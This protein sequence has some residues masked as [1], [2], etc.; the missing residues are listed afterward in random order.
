MLYKPNFCCQCGEKIQRIDWNLRASRRFCDLCQT[1]FTVYEL[2]PK[3]GLGIGLLLG[4]FF[5]GSF[6]RTADKPENALPDKASSGSQQNRDLPE[7]PKVK[8]L[9]D[10]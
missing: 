4:I 6:F 7:Q 1:E 10:I 5:I 9:A 8:Q 3:I 2:M